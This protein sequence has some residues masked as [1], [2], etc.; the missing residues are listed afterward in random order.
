MTALRATTHAEAVVL[1]PQQD[2]WDVLVDP[3]L[4]G[5]VHVLFVKRI[6]AD[7]DHWRWEMRRSRGAG[8]ER[9]PGVHRADGPQGARIPAIEFHQ[10]P[11]EGVRGEG[12]VRSRAE[13]GVTSRVLRGSTG[14]APR[15]SPTLTISLDLAAARCRQV[16]RSR[17]LM[18]RVIDTMGDRFSANLLAHAGGRATTT[19]APLAS[20]CLTCS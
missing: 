12:R 18:G 6:T 4:I 5:Q 17:A 15:S 19:V 13:Y 9:H 8:Q 16:R 20:D 11:P 7:G 1:A 14:A 10:D 3:D 2:I